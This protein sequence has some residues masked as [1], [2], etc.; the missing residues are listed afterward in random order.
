MRLALRFNYLIL[1][2]LLSVSARAADQRDRFIFRVADQVVSLQ[3][4]KS[5]DQDWSALRCHLPDSLIIEY[6]GEAFRKKL[7]EN[8][9]VLE[10]LDKPLGANAP[11]TIFLGSMRSFW[12]L[13]TYIDNQEVGLLPELEKTFLRSSHCPSVEGEPKKLRASFRRWLRVEIYLRS[14]YGQGDISKDGERIQKRHQSI[15][16][17]V[18]SLDKQVTHEDFW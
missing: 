18:D 11:L 2:F 15:S 6:V 9:G 10:K 1:A 16:L 7:Q 3:D 17:F 13:L 12:K 4:L 8:I 5:T 14:R